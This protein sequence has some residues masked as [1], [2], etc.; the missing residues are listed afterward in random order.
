M[1][2]TQAVNKRRAIKYSDAQHGLTAEE[3]RN[4]KSTV[5]KK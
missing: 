5:D 3:E 2:A 1:N 4:E